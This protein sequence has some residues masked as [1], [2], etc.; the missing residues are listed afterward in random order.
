M[1]ELRLDPHSDQR[2]LDLWP[3][4][5]AALPW[6]GRS[7]RSLARELVQARLDDFRAGTCGVDNSA[8]RCPRREPPELVDPRQLQIWV[9]TQ[10]FQRR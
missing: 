9:P 4:E 3:R 5:V 1:H 7:P 8:V 2:Q 10:S 6:G